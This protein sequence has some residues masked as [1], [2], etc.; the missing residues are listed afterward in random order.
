MS[1]KMQKVVTKIVAN[2]GRTAEFAQALAERDEF[3]L[4]AKVPG[5]MKL[6]IE[7]TPAGEVSVA[8]YT[9][10]GCGDTMRDPEIV[11]NPQTWHA[12]EI[13]Q[14]FLGQ[15]NRAKPGCYLKNVDEFATFWAGNLF[16]QGFT[17]T[18][19]LTD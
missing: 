11:F 8:H 2:A 16:D 3:H 14:D 12:V 13:T 18:S 6:V 10:S 4:V 17:K 5:F 15:Y 1:S 9:T 7:A 19:D